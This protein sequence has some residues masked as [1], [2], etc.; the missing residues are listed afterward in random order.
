MFVEVSAAY[1]SVGQNGLDAWEGRLFL[2]HAF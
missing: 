2:S 1:L